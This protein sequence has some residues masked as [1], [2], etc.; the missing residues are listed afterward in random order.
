MYDIML[1]HEKNIAKQEMILK[2][3]YLIDPNQVIKELSGYPIP[4]DNCDTEAIDDLFHTIFEKIYQAS[5]LYNRYLDPTYN[6]HES[7]FG[8]PGCTSSSGVDYLAYSTLLGHI[9][10]FLKLSLRN[11]CITQGFFNS[12]SEKDRDGHVP[13]SAKYERFLQSGYFAD[14]IYKKEDHAKVDSG[15]PVYQKYNSK[16]KSLRRSGEDSFMWRIL[17]DSSLHMNKSIA[18]DCTQSKFKVPLVYKN[19]IHALF[20]DSGMIT[21]SKHIKTKQKDTYKLYMRI[22]ESLL[23]EENT[24]KHPL[25][26]F[27]FHTMGEYYLGFSTLSYINR[28]ME[29]I[30]R[31]SSNEDIYLKRYRGQILESTLNRL[32]NCPMPYARHLFFAYALE[33]L[34]Y[35]ENVECKFL[36]NSPEIG[37]KRSPMKTPFTDEERDALGLRLIPRFFNTL[38]HITLPILS[39]LWKIVTEQ[40]LKDEEFLFDLYKTYVASHDRLLTADLST[41]SLD[42]MADCCSDT[43]PNTP[44][45]DIC[46]PFSLKILEQ[47]LDV[48]IPN[49]ST[50]FADKIF[51]QK[52]LSAMICDFL[53][54]SLEDSDSPYVYKL[55]QTEQT[56][57]HQISELDRFRFNRANNI[58]GLFSSKW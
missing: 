5:A 14:P 1:L 20:M 24:L 4:K 53:R 38:D 42:D 2:F 35:N 8:E 57:I 7:F 55:F 37:M 25:D 39:S 47:K 52:N 15:D 3:F 51:H 46:A 26:K 19:W 18:Y 43:R 28:L 50:I 32:S 11:H 6:S 33:A 45:N 29:R 36:S 41:L 12:L 22:Y 30:H 56:G 49:G 16:F 58:F 21:L 40:I 23:L 44:P 54:I 10:T 17:V 27:V 48:M 13:L 34:R 31:P 9:R